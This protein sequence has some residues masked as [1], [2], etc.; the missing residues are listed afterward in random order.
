MTHTGT[1]RGRGAGGS[2]SVCNK[3]LSVFADVAPIHEFGADCISDQRYIDA[4]ALDG[5]GHF[6]AAKMLRSFDLKVAREAA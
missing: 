1:Q 5:A 6:A 2:G 3:S 4:D